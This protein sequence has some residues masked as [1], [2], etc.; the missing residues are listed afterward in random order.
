MNEYTCKICNKVKPESDFYIVQG[1]RRFGCKKCD[2]QINNKIRT[3]RNQERK[4]KAIR[5]LG[6]KCKKC[7]YNKCS[8]ALEF[9]HKD[10]SKKEFEIKNAI[11]KY[12]WKRVIPELKKCIL[13]CANCHREIH[14]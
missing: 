6:G 14:N 12:S 3:K 10:P 8:A 7:G 5:L 13:L 11:E 1:Y 4:L 9:H 2:N